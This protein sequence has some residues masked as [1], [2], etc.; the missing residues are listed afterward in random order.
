MLLTARVYSAYGSGPFLIRLN[1][2]GSPDATFGE[3]G[4][5]TIGRDVADN[6]AS[7]L[8]A[9][10]GGKVI[11]A[12]SG[13]YLVGEFDALHAVRFNSDGTLDSSY[14]Y[15]AFAPGVA[16]APVRLVDN[17]NYDT[18]VGPGGSIFRL[19]AGDNF[20]ELVERRTAAGA[21]KPFVVARDPLPGGG[22]AV[23]LSAPRT[24]AV[25]ADGKFLI[26]HEEGPAWF[27]SKD[28]SKIVR[29][30]ADGTIDTSFGSGGT[31]VLPIQGFAA[32]KVFARSDGS[33]AVAAKIWSQLQI[34]IIYEQLFILDSAGNVTKSGTIDVF[35]TSGMTPQSGRTLVNDIVQAPDGKFL[36]SASISAP[37]DVVDPSKTSVLVQ[38]F[39]SDLTLDTTFG[40][41]GTVTLHPGVAS[42]GLLAVA[43]DG[44]VYVQ[45]RK[46]Q[47]DSS[48]DPFIAR[49][50]PN[51]A[52]DTAFG[53]A[54]YLPVPAEAEPDGKLLITTSH[55]Y[56]VRVARYNVDGSLDATFGAN[57][58][59]S[60]WLGA[61]ASIVR[62]HLQ[63]TTAGTKLLVTG[64]LAFTPVQAG[65]KQ[66]KFFVLRVD[67]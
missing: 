67:L 22:I 51:G 44:H 16:T 35:E 20:N 38:R 48:G 10:A 52:L 33:I 24:I 37:V 13:H 50:M 63:D 21:P 62:L 29:Y 5:R 55:G 40:S 57:G 30:N 58:G 14:A 46:F 3:Q 54:G 66:A 27:R 34:P 7:S 32:L 36:L 47:L 53:Q 61:P 41:A 12:F 9:Q 4:V 18:A 6:V 31:V 19:G 28:A 8:L 60:I 17:P 49:L 2:D 43:A 64:T 25:Q 26:G 42:A 39:N 65:Q 56:S 45:G 59:S 15:G 11:V 1:S 23:E